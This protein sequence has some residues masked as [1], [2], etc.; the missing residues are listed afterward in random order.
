MSQYTGTLRGSS[1]DIDSIARSRP[2]SSIASMSR[3]VSG[4]SPERDMTGSIWDMSMILLRYARS[5]NMEM[6]SETLMRS[7]DGS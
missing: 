7:I 5:V 1:D 4:C 2:A 3:R 6:F